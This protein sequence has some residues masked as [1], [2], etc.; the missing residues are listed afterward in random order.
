MPDFNPTTITIAEFSRW[1]HRAPFEPF[2]IRMSNGD[3][4][5]VPTPDHLIITKI[6]RRVTVEMDDGR[7]FDINPLHVVSIAPIKTAA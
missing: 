1:L 5:E 6:L 4:Y 3:A 2:A 7:A